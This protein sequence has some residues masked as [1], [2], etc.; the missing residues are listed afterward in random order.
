MKLGGIPPIWLV[1]QVHDPVEMA[2]A[3]VTIKLTDKA[4]D[5]CVKFLG[6]SAEHAVRNV[7]LFYSQVSKLEIVKQYKIKT[8]TH[9]DNKDLIKELGPVNESSPSDE[10]QQKEDLEEENTQ[11]QEDMMTLRKEYWA[12]FEQLLGLSSIPD[13]QHIVQVKMNTKG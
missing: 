8:K 11:I 9:K 3:T 12:L 6:G 2:E 7:K 4:K 13:W 5:T 1:P 10:I